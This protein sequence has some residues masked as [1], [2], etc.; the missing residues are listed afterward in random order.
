MNC[1][2]SNITKLFR[3]IFIVKITDVKDEVWNSM[4]RR[5]KNKK[6]KNLELCP[7]GGQSHKDDTDCCDA[8]KLGQW[9]HRQI[10][11]SW[12]LCVM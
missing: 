11:T 9:V 3:Y 6:K 4:M 7:A 1:F 10:H 12:H 8:T 5:V 2:H